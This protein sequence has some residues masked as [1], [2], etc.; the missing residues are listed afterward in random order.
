MRT[1]V[2]TRYNPRIKAFYERLARCGESQKS[3][4]DGLYAEVLDD[5][6][7]DAEAS[8]SLA[9]PSG[10]GLKN[11]QGPLTTKTVA[12]LVP[13]SGS[14]PRLRPSA[15]PQRLEPGKGGRGP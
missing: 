2:A 8:D 3:G 13:S 7:R 1:L 6:Q 4:S 11:I 9:S 5:S 12:P 15:T 14:F 10:P